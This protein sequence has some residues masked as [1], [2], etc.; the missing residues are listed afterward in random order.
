MTKT[1]KTER[2][3]YDDLKAFSNLKLLQL[4][5]IVR[6]RFVSALFGLDLAGKSTECSEYFTQWLT[7]QKTA[8]QII[9]EIDAE[10]E[11]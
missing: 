9:A 6:Y 1:G 8:K 7:E 11:D 2:K 3:F 10:S 4:P 5:E